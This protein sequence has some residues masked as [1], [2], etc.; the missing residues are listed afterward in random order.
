MSLWKFGSELPNLVKKLS[1][2]FEDMYKMQIKFSRSGMFP[3]SRIF[4]RSE[5]HRK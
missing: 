3:R 4:T 1:F 2:C 5:L